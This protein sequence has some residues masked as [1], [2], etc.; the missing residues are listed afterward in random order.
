ME[1]CRKLESA[2]IHGFKDLNNPDCDM[3]LPYKMM[4]NTQGLVQNN[5]R[6]S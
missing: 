2:L 6:T 1:I 4:G 5:Y 3:S